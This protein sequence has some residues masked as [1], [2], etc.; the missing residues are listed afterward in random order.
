MANWNDLFSGGLIMPKFTALN[1]KVQ[2]KT[3]TSSLEN[4][5]GTSF[6]TAVENDFTDEGWDV[7]TLSPVADTSE[8]TIAIISGSGILTTV[9]SPKLT[10]ATGTITVRIKIDGTTTTFVIDVGIQDYIGVIGAAQGLRSTTLVGSSATVGGGEDTGF[11][12]TDQYIAVMTP[13]QAISRSIAGMPF[14]TSCEV[15]V[16]GS[17]AFTNSATNFKAVMMTY[18][19]IPEGL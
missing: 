2:I 17:S 19:S 11:S 16:Q 5:A 7:D 10:A 18:S 13:S 8:Q 6:Y 4:A 12:A 15:T 3:A 9:V 14:K 1:T